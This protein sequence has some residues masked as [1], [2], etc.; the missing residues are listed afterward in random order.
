MNKKFIMLAE[1]NP[2]D[3][4]LTMRALNKNSIINEVIVVRDGQEALDF[5]YATGEY[6]DR[7][8]SI[9]PEMLLLD[10]KMPK[11]DGLGVLR[12]IR[13]DKRT[14]HLPVIMLTSSDEESDL[15]ASY[16]LGVNSYVRKPVDF[17]QFIEAVNQL[18]L[19]W[20]VLNKVPP[21]KQV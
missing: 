3:E 18:S 14:K 4:A 15:I 16:N 8:T 7:D 11:I 5:L 13:E 1:D 20:L 12:R 21:K 10:L 9:L 2:D 6:A 19:Y 17:N